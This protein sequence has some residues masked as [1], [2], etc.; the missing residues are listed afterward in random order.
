LILER[1][2]DLKSGTAAEIDRVLYREPSVD[3]SALTGLSRVVFPRRAR[4]EPYLVAVR[5]RFAAIGAAL[6]DNQIGQ[7]R[8]EPD[9]H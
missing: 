7:V 9:T 3:D 2:D 5:P 4:A 8:I 6:R 1:L